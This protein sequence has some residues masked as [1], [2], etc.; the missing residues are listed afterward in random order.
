M[1]MDCLFLPPACG[2]ELGE[3]GLLYWQPESGPGQWLPASECAARLEGRG[4]TL[5]LPMEVASAFLISL[6]TQKARWMRQALPYAV[7]ELL[8][9]DVE[10][11]HLALGEMTGDG[12]YRVFALRRALLGA[13]LDELQEYGLTVAAIYLD[14]DLLPRNGEQALA[15]GERVL[16][17]G[18]LEARVAIAAERW[19]QFRSFCGTLV[20]PTHSDDPYA[21]LAQGRSKAVDLAQG[22]FAP[23]SDNKAWTIWRPFAALLGVWA[24]LYLGTS[25]V[26]AWQL[27]H[28][29][30]AFNAAS[31]ALYKELFPEDQRI[32]NLKA[33][34]AEHLSQGQQKEGGFL[35]MLEQAS[36]AIAEAKSPLSVVQVDYS[37]VRGDLALQIRAKDF[38]ALEQLR[39]RLIEGG[40][41]VQLGSASRE[42]EGITARVVLGGGA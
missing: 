14:A 25:V 23:R 3:Q 4:V 40:I 42:E 31:V 26:Q 29:G 28:R 5:V 10:L 20:Q 12:R 35:S 37:Q 8:A 13:W 1:I 18:E 22:E 27:E 6:P 36:A 11:F 41:K 32:V 19:P 21:L 24:L 9:E 39:Q 7:E 2:R 30:D 33:Q 34:F 15:L 17:G 38:A 16:L